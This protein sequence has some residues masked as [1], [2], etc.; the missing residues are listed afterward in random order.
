[1]LLDD[2][3]ALGTIRQVVPARLRNRLDTL[4]VSTVPRA[5]A[6]APRS[7]PMDVLRTLAD[8]IRAHVVLRFDYPAEDAAGT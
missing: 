2:D 7:L 6:P 5:G 4:D 3:Q 1:M 8:A